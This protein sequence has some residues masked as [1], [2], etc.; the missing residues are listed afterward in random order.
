MKLTRDLVVMDIETTGVWIEKD[1]IIEIALMKCSAAGE[2]TT[3]HS[4]VNPGMKIPPVVVELTGISDETVATAPPF[5]DIAV[6]VLQFLDGCDL[7]G[8]NLERFDLPLLERECSE[9]GHSFLWRAR[10]IFDAQKVFHLNEK[11]DLSAAYAF[12]CGKPMQNAHSA[13]AD[14]EATL[15]ILEGQVKRYGGGRDDIEVLQA[16]EY[17]TNADFFDDERK[18]RWWNGELYMMFGKYAKKYPLQEIARRDKKYLEWVLSADFSADV[19]ELV[20]DALHG[21]FPAP[22]AAD[23][24]EIQQELF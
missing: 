4:F 11:R 8:F 5:K 15:E 9:A 18:F 1:K 14:A 20:T 19:K 7:A 16:F 21:K 10:R 24:K 22:P 12:Y 3:Y 13:L 2:R 23:V 6:A 17:K